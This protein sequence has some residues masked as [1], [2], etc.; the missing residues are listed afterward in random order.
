MKKQFNKKIKAAILAGILT[1]SFNSVTNAE[2][3]LPSSIDFSKEFRLNIEYGASAGSYKDYS[4]LYYTPVDKTV[5]DDLRNKV[6]YK[7]GVLYLVQG[8]INSGYD[9]TTVTI[10][11]VTNLGDAADIFGEGFSGKLRK[12]NRAACAAP[13]KRMIMMKRVCVR[14]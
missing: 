11:K 12:K 5:Q 9:N 10:D 4:Y 7:G 14:K 2:T 13:F 1:L 8:Y 6:T 3:I